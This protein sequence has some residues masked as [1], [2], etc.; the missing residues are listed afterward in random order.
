MADSDKNILITPNTNQSGFPNIQFVGSSS[1]PISLNVLDDNTISFTGSEGQLFSISN[2]LTVGTIFSVNDVSGIPSIEVDADGT[3]SLAEF[4]GNVGIGTASPTY[5]LSVTGTLGVSGATTLTSVSGTTAEFTSLTSSNGALINNSLTLQSTGDAIL[6][7]DADTDNGPTELDNPHIIM[8]QDGKNTAL[9]M[10]INGNNNPTPPIG[11]GTLTGGLGNYAAIYPTLGDGGSPFAWGLQLGVGNDTSA[12]ATVLMTL[13]Y[14]NQNIGIGTN[15][16]I[17]KVHVATNQS[18]E[19]FGIDR[20][21]PSDGL[22]GFLI[23]SGAV[24]AADLHVTAVDTVAAMYSINKNLALGVSTTLGDFNAGL[25][26]PVGGGAPIMA[27]ITGINALELQGN[28]IFDTNGRG[29]DFGNSAGAGSQSTVLDDY[30]EGTWTPG[31]ILNGIAPTYT[32]QTGNYIKVGRMVYVSWYV[33]FTATTTSTAGSFAVTGL[34]FQYDN[35]N[36]QTVATGPNMYATV[37][38]STDRTPSYTRLD[39][40]ERIFQYTF[41]PSTGGNLQ[42]SINGIQ[43]TNTNLYTTQGSFVYR[44]TT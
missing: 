7:I 43:F 39:S 17:T 41:N 10:G 16:P 24:G 22:N 38:P 28:L 31:I 20:S 32:T 18:G 26:I 29:I 42:S 35:S 44:S 40:A 23:M 33:F 36:N 1:A 5:K 15:N 30:E 12:G 2:N 13:R 21:G 11:G 34:P 19:Y 37:S 27:P 6:R 8:T 9:V 3:V 4:G 14:D 25:T